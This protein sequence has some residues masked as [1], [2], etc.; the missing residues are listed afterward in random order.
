MWVAVIMLLFCAPLRLILGKQCGSFVSCP[1]RMSSSKGAVM[2]RNVLGGELQKCCGEPLTGYY[3]DGSCRTGRSDFGV[4]TV[5]AVVTKTFLDYSKERGNDLMT[6]RRE[7]N[8]P[9]LKDGDKWCLCASRW[10]EAL[11]G[12]VAPPVVLQATHEK[13]L[14]FVGIDLLQEHAFVLK[15]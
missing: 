10:K 11:D 4:H 13:T 14:E 8:F 2:E 12:G 5:C 1:V 3:R 15:E 9:G 7:S 6:P